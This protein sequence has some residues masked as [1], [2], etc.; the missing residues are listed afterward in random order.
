MNGYN[1]L[2]ISD[3]ELVEQIVARHPA[4]LAELYDRHARLLHGIILSVVRNAHDTED[5]LQDVFVQVWRSAATYQAALASPKRWLATMAH[6]RAID[7]L[8]SRRYQQRKLEVAG[9]DDE[10][11]G[12]AF[13]VDDSAW[14]Y[15]VEAELAHYLSAALATLPSSQRELI[16]LA[17][18]EGYSH[19]EIAEK[20]GIALGT[21]KTRIR[22][23]MMALRSHLESVAREIL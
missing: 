14:R 18:F 2:S 13:A 3:T 16:A 22:T 21:V 12:A 5:I 17:F 11:P 15:A 9:D 23:G 7:M 1:T 10:G 20:T 4:A 6:N 19:S 8:R